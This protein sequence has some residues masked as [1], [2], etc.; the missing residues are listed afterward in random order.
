M[1]MYNR[2]Q[3]YVMNILT[4]NICA[5][6]I[7]VLKFLSVT[8]NLQVVTIIEFKNCD[9]NNRDNPMFGLIYFE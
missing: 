2:Q 1:A 5:G 8:N 4:N 7:G 9:S 6:W 3:I